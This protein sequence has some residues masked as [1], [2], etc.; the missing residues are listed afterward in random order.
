MSWSCSGRD[1]AFLAAGVAAGAASASLLWRRGARGSCPKEGPRLLPPPPRV[2]DVDN[3][4]F[5][6]DELCGNASNGDS[7]VSIADV[8]VATTT[9]EPPQTTFF[10]E[11]IL[12][13]EGEVRIRVND[14]KEPSLAA[15]AGRTLWLPK[16]YR[17]EYLFPARC[18]YVPVCLPAF[19]PDLTDRTRA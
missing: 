15:T 1:L 2:V 6:I 3:G 16:G 4:K 8:H 17:Y 11:Y 12:V 5:T 14:E 13:L 9:T 7:R 18:R 19:H 10:D